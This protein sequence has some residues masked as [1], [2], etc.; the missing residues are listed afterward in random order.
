MARLPRVHA[1]CSEV[2]D[3][4]AGDVSGFWRREE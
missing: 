4:P 1:K 3:R 2:L